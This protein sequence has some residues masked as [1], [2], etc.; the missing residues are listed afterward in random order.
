MS[1]LYHF[2]SLSLKCYKNPK[3]LPISNNSP[4]FNEICNKQENNEFLSF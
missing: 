2:N 1:V 3:K 4:Y